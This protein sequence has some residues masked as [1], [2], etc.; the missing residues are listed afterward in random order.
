MSGIKLQYTEVGTVRALRGCIVFVRG[1]RNCINGQLIKFGYG[2]IG[3][4]VGFN[5]EEAQVLI[6][7]ETERIK[8]GDKATASIEP[9][10]TP[11]G[12][13][14]IGRILNPL[15][16]PL[17]GLGPV[18]WDQKMTIFPESPPILVRQPLKLTLET[19]I[20]VLD[21][22]IPIGRGQRELI[23]GDKSTGKTT[24]VTDTIINQKNTDVICI[25]CAIGKPR[26]ALAKIVQLFKEHDCFKYSLIVSSGASA[27]PGQQ[28]LA[29]YMA[30][31]VAEYF[32]QQGKHVFIG[33]DDFT[34]HAWCYR[35]ISL[36][37]GRPPGRDSYPG[38]IF[39]LHSKMIERA[40]YLDQKRGGGSVTF[41]PI[42]E[43]LEGDLTAF[44]PSNLVSMTDGQ[45][46]LS[47]TLFGE[48]QKPALDLG[49]SVSRVGSKVQWPAIKSLSGPLRLE[50]LQYRELLRISKLKATGHSDETLEK[51]KR[52]AILTEILRQDKDRPV[53]QEIQVIIFYAFNKKMMNELTIPEVRLF[54]DELLG[55]AL[56]NAP[57]VLKLVREKRKL[58][59]DV[60]KAI[61][62]FVNRYV[63][64]ITSKRAKVA[65]DKFDDYV[66]SEPA[67]AAKK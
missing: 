66:D 3:M 16:E 42:V 19:G 34:K 35:E 50:Y 61:T 24:F 49:L 51:L 62:D 47:T 1:F 40:C 31:S 14:F 15:A 63:Q 46:Y 9:F 65:T 21:A 18:E 7:K 26:S 8:T 36:L 55:Y 33:F 11:V 53:P 59:P 58:E 13:K 4:I 6:I 44:V 54:Q 25:Y 30:C 57:D 32:L 22:M 23:M 12:S 27:P 41:F 60:E 20:K 56:K 2:T 37:L 17:D 39:Y 43:I 38:D 45:I 48:G 10:E 64:D 52:G 29:P 28:Y 67:V 5:E